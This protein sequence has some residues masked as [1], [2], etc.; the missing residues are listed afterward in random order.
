M[1]IVVSITMSRSMSPVAWSMSLAC[2]WMKVKVKVLTLWGEEEDGGGFSVVCYFP[3]GV[4]GVSSTL[5]TSSVID[6]SFEITNTS[7]HA[8]GT[9]CQLKERPAASQ[10]LHTEGEIKTQSYKKEHS[11]ACASVCE[12]VFS[13]DFFLNFNQNRCIKTAGEAV[14]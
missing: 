7:W 11:T 12:C 14:I 10:A 5:N 2:A 1:F 13:V 6:V 9:A 4:R 3:R 8:A